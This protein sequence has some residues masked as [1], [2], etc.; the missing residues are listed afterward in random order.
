MRFAPSRRKTAHQRLG[1]ARGYAPLLALVCA[2]FSS[3]CET[4]TQLVVQVNAD[5]PTY[6][7]LRVRVEGGGEVLATRSFAPF[8]SGSSFTLVPVDS[9]DFTERHIVVMGALGEATWETAFDATFVASTRQ[10]VEVFLG[11][12]D[13]GGGDGGPPDAGDA[14]G[15]PLDA[16][17]P[18]AD[19]GTGQER[20]A[21]ENSSE[22]VDSTECILG[23]CRRPCADQSDCDGPPGAGCISNSGFTFCTFGCEANVDCPEGTEC[24]LVLLRS[25]AITACL[26]GMG[27][28][29][30]DECRAGECDPGLAC[31]PLPATSLGVCIRT[32]DRDGR[33]GGGT[34][35]QPLPLTNDGQFGICSS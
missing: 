19:Q 23:L 27:K 14:D 34:L 26:R 5:R 20:S 9:S 7:S 12:P 8:E 6:D 17:S 35:C 32:C 24:D 4:P 30:G 29:L 1:T 11:D 22:C 18:D 21:C 3:G 15:G 33:C 25:E 13:A 16:N 31:L 10:Y 2:L 28:A